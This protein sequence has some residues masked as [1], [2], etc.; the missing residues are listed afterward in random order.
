MFR[1]QSTDYVME[2][3]SLLRSMSN[4]LDK[5]E[6]AN[7]EAK[8]GAW[9]LAVQ[10]ALEELGEQ[11][12]KGIA[13]LCARTEKK[14]GTGEFL[15]DAVWWRRETPGAVEHIALAVESEFAGWAKNRGDVAVEVAKDFEKLLVVKSPLKLMIFCS[16]YGKG[17][18]DLSPMRD[19]IW[20]TLKNYIV[21]YSHHIEGEKYLFLD[22]GV[23][24]NRK[25]WIFEIPQSGSVSM[26]EIEKGCVSLDLKGQV[27]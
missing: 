21:Q 15:L 25:A 1:F 19:K 18:T 5:F 16:W 20:S 11:T 23:K 13:H 10:S 3:A 4:K 27:A 22:T 6:T 2:P 7:P 9:T 24:D 14:V 8:T 26:E 12:E 17:D